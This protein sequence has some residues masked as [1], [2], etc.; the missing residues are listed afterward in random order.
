MRTTLVVALPAGFV[1][2]DG[3]NPKR[4]YEYGK[5]VP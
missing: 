2:A 5:A 1:K 4:E 3:K